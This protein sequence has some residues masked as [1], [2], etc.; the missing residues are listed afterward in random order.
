MNEPQY[1]YTAKGPCFS[2]T[3]DKPFELKGC[4]CGWPVTA[5]LRHQ[6]RSMGEREKSYEASIWLRDR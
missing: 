1:T 5:C 4:S 3:N 6:G 2:I